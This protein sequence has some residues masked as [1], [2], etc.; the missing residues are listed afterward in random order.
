MVI[1]MSVE[2]ILKVLKENGYDLGEAENWKI[3]RTYAGHIQR[4]QGSFSWYLEW[5]GKE[6]CTDTRLFGSYYPASM[7][8][9]GITE[10]YGYAVA[11]YPKKLEK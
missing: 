7:C 8:K 10:E 5:V 4:S 3:Q 6:P 9:N 11:I 2:N 1:K